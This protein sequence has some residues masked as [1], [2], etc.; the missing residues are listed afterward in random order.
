MDDWYHIS[1]KSIQEKGG[2]TILRKYG[3]SPSKM[4]ISLFPDHIWMKWRFSGFKEDLNREQR[5]N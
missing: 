2:H 3:G 5:D 1:V 4:V